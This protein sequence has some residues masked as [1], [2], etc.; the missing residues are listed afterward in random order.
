MHRS[1]EIVLIYALTI[2]AA[3]LFV[4]AFPIM[5]IFGPRRMYK[6]IRSKPHMTTVVYSGATVKKITEVLDADPGI[7]LYKTKT[8]DVP[9][10]KNSDMNIVVWLASPTDAVMFELKYGGDALHKIIGTDQ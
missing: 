5:C 4:I 10:T 9:F 1:I 2:V 3:I 6:F 8:T 7:K